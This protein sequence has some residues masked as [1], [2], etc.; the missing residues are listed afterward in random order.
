MWKW[1]HCSSG[2]RCLKRAFVL[3]CSPLM[4]YRWQPISW[5]NSNPEAIGP[6]YTLLKRLR[7][8]ETPNATPT[9][10][11][12][13]NRQQAQIRTVANM[14][15]NVDACM[16]CPDSLHFAA[17]FSFHITWSTPQFAFVGGRFMTLCTRTLLAS[18]LKIR[19]IIVNMVKC[20]KN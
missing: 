10:S 4:V 19:S 14:F 6:K 12:H 17:L 5:M 18:L 16:P 2:C 3:R 9:S 8:K 7:P 20:L 1:D 11:L 15:W 13:G